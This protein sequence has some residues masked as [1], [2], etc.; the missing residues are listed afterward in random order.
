MGEYGGL[1]TAA[2]LWYMPHATDPKR[3]LGSSHA[4]SDWLYEIWRMDY[5]L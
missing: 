2:Y 5:G 3:G 4:G 1:S